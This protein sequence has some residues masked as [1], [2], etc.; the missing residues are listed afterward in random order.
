[1][2]FWFGC[3]CGAREEHLNFQQLSQQ[4]SIRYFVLYIKG[5]LIWLILA[6]NSHVL[7]GCWLSLEQKLCR[8]ITSTESE[9]QSPVKFT[10]HLLFNSFINIFVVGILPLKCHGVLLRLCG[11]NP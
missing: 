8:E 11:R 2:I 4:E 1:M 10:S 5:Y 7:F 6:L 9:F 3:G